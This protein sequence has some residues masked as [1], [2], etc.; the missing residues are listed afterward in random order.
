MQ[1]N[2]FRPSFDNVKILS[3]AF[4]C[5]ALM[6][7]APHS[8]ADGEFTAA[9]NTVSGFVDNL[10]MLLRFVSV[11][12]VTVAIIFAGYQIAFAHKRFSDVA[13]IL[14]GGLLIGGAGQI[15]AWFVKG[16]ETTAAAC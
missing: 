11:G 13:P 2:N 10:V 4:I 1:S 14:I 3:I 8:F 5:F 15:A 16:A 12:I 7:Y 9:C 6:A